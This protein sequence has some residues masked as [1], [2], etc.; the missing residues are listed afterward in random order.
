MTP[1]GAVCFVSELFG[2][3]I[4]D[5]ELVIHSHFLGLMPSIGYGA[6]IMA[7]NGF[8]IQDL[9]VPYGVKL[10]IP[11]F[12]QTG[13]Q[14]SLQD[15]QRTQQIAKVRIHIERLIERIKDMVQYFQQDHTR[16]HVPGCESDVGGFF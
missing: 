7:D 6:S 1:D 8:N 11:P 3:S 16:H 10:N 4:S 15:V 9:L 12:K 5:Q 14:M 2:G 13:V